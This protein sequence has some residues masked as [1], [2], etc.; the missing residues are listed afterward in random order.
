M[1]GFFKGRH[2]IDNV[3]Q[4]QEA[5]HSIYQRKEKGMIVKLDI[6]NTFDRVNLNF[7]Y[8]VLHS[9]GFS[10]EFVRLIKA[11]TDKL[12]ISPLVNGRPT[13]FFQAMR[14]LRQGCPLSPFLYILMAES[15]PGNSLLK[16]LQVLSQV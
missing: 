7:L 14:G 8:Q 4:V 6:K 13:Y 12:W 5:V 11:C 3:I 15:L 16:W 10:G 9:F 1:G 2:L